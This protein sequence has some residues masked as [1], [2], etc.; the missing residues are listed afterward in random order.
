MTPNEYLDAIAELIQARAACEDK[1][2]R[3]QALDVIMFNIANALRVYCKLKNSHT[4][5][6]VPIPFYGQT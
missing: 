2:K 4:E 5:Y 1:E 3:G 6:S